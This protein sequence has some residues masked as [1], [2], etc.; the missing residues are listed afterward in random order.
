[1]ILKISRYRRNFSTTPPPP[2]FEPKSGVLPS[3][4]NARGRGGG[5]CINFQ[6]ANAADIADE[7]G[8]LV[9]HAWGALTFACTPLPLLHA[10]L[11][12]RRHL[13]GP[14]LTI[15][16]FFR[17]REYN[18]FGGIIVIGMHIRVG[19]RLES[20][21]LFWGEGVGLCRG[22]WPLLLMRGPGVGGGLL[23][24]VSPMSSGRRLLVIERNV[25]FCLRVVFDLQLT[26]KRIFRY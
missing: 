2:H 9:E 12:L 18:K 1:M 17:V 13:I 21:R 22:T 10:F 20:R 19:R 11:L 8:P 26:L 24:G 5:A 15:G 6:S 23:K 3:G 7:T 14:E 25:L 4:H 16:F